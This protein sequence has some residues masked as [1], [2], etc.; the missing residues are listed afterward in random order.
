[1]LTR[2]RLFLALTLLALMTAMPAR[3]EL[4]P[5]NLPDLIPKLMPGVVSISFTKLESSQGMNTNSAAPLV[6]VH[7]GVG[8]GYIIDE[9]GII[10]T[11]RHVTDGGQELFVTFSDQ[12][13][14]PAELI[15]RSPDIDMA[16]LKVKPTHKLQTVTFGDSDALV[17][18]DQIIAIGNPLG[19]SG[20]VTTGIVSALD[21][22]IHETPLDAFIQID[23]AINPGNSG[24]PLFNT[25]GEVV[26][27]N[28]ALYSVPGSA[29][30]GS[31]GL[32]F[33]IPINQVKFILDSLHKYGRMRRGYLGAYMQDINPGLAE[34]WGLPRVAGAIVASV[35]P[36]SPAAEGG[37]QPGDILK[38]VDQTPIENLRAALRQVAVRPMEEASFLVLRGGKEVTLGV[39]LGEEKA[40]SETVDMRMGAIPHMAL[41]AQDLGIT[42]ASL[43]PELRK[44]FNLK[45]DAQGVVLTN[46]T[47]GLLGSY[48]GLATGNL[49][50]RA[51]DRPITSLAELEAAAAATRAAG[52]TRIALL[53]DDGTGMAWVAVPLEI[54]D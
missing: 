24:G 19:L 27:M 48:V 23:A 49:I 31:I 34:A 17:Q 18:G 7:Q 13:R 36:G 12:S 33:S 37:L 42:G 20:T 6:P 14:L 4:P 45:P 30:S 11:N 47:Q 38:K 39:H 28:T 16:L 32:N 46:V 29:A 52:R 51:G 21:R 5:A 1:M 54:G 25:K 15:Y 10:A 2:L 50:I 41:T 40:E 9:R 43:T 44:Q 8:T 3:A 26:G 53:V 35:Q 22:D